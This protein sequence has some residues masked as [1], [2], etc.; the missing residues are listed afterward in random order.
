M[1]MDLRSSSSHSVQ[2]SDQER[3]R[4][5]QSPAALFFLFFSSGF[6]SL[7]RDRVRSMSPSCFYVKYGRI[8]FSFFCLFFFLIKKNPT[9][10]ASAFIKLTPMSEISDIENDFIYKSFSLFLFPFLPF[11]TP[12]F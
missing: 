11:S 4:S 1:E 9:K 6:P 2:V 8:F 5:D 7:L 12:F 3:R 10:R